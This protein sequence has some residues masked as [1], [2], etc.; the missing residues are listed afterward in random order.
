MDGSTDKIFKVKILE[1]SLIIRRVKIS[2]GLLL[3]HA[4]TLAK[5]PAKY[6]ITR[7]EIKSF[8]LKTGI[9][10]KLLII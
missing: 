2:P 1:A 4:N 6:P 3:S 9:M 5:T 7:V 10:E 8:I